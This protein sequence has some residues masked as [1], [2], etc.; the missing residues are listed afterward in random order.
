MI[1]KNVFFFTIPEA[2]SFGTST[3]LEDVMDRGEE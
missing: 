2:A 1:I 3:L